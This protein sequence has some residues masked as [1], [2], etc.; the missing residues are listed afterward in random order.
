MLAGSAFGSSG[1]L[2]ADVPEVRE[3][4][5]SFVLLLSGEIAQVHA[6]RT[7]RSVEVSQVA[8]S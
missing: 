6:M 7:G 8:V 1:L 3:G 4:W 2:A 5:L